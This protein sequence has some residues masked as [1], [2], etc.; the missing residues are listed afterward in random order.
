[1]KELEERTYGQ[2]KSYFTTTAISQL[3]DDDFVDLDPAEPI[4]STYG[5][6]SRSTIE[7]E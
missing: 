1:V 4:T 6:I 3:L 5:E 2:E 7:G